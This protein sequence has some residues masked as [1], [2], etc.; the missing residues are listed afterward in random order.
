MK[1]KYLLAIFLV[2]IIV[3]MSG[4]DKRNEHQSTIS[5][6]GTGTVLA[7]PDVIQ[8]YITLSNVAQTT[9]AAQEAV[10]LMVRR[11]ITVLKEAGIED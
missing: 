4:C 9:K 7:Q 3:A 5:V 6:F 10:N 1:T 11:A 8:M 2:L